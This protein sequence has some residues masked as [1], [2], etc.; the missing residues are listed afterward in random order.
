MVYNTLDKKQKNLLPKVEHLC[1]VMVVVVV[2]A[3]TGYLVV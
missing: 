1:R 3:P 2:V